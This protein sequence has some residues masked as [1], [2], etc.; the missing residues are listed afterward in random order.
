MRV[1]RTVRD[2]ENA[3]LTL[4]EDHSFEHLTVEQICQEAL[5]HRSSFYRYFRDKYDLLEQTLETQLNR[6]DSNLSQD[7]VIKKLIM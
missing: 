4:L 6:F 2:F 5:L 1:T 7:D 3:L